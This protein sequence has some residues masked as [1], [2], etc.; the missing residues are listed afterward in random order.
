MAGLLSLIGKFF[1]NKYE[2]DIKKIAPIVE[3]I[4]TEYAKLNN[5]SHDELRAKTSDLQNTI[6]TFIFKDKEEIIRLKTKAESDETSTTDKDG[7]YAWLIANTYK[8]GFI[9]TVSTEEWHFEYS[10]ERAK[11]GP[12]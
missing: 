5:L 4:K 1:G 7:V 3:E 10:P 2:K 8:F 9:R 12:F 11:K 6:S